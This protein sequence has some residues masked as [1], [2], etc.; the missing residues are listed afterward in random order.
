MSTFVFL[1]LLHVLHFSLINSANI[2]DS[3]QIGRKDGKCKLINSCPEVKQNYQRYNI[4]PTLCDSRT[5]SV[6]CPNPEVIETR[7]KSERVSALSES[8][9]KYIEG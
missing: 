7:I 5:R 4:K 9:W 6:C 3:C 2:G 8:F 1:I